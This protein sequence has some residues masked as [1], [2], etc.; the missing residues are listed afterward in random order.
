MRQN[1]KNLKCHKT[2]EKKY[3]KTQRLKMW[4]TLKTQNVTKL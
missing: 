4:Q 2:E 1:S 3:D